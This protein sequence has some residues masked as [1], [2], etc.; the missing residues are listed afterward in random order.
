MGELKH[1]STP[2]KINYSLSSGERKGRS[3]NSVSLTVLELMFMEGCKA[4]R[5]ELR[6]GRGVT[7]RTLVEGFWKGPP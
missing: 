6:I 2:R 4:G 3:L 7:D 5:T 1:L